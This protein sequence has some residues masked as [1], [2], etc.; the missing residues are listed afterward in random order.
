MANVASKKAKGLC[1]CNWKDNII[2][3]SNKNSHHRII[4]SFISHVVLVNNLRVRYIAPFIIDS[5]ISVTIANSNIVISAIIQLTEEVKLPVNQP[6]PDIISILQI[7]PVR[8][9]SLSVL[10]VISVYIESG[11]AQVQEESTVTLID[12][13]REILTSVRSFLKLIQSPIYP[14]LYDTGGYLQ[15]QL[16]K[17]GMKSE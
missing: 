11:I 15:I 13:L 7:G 3:R 10:S 14:S 12:S 1:Y 8:I 6:N 9:T 4:T 2:K 16:S 17:T 5:L